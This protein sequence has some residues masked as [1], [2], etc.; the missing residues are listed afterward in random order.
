MPQSTAQDT[1]K[2]SGLTLNTQN[3][4]ANLV[5]QMYLSRVPAPEPPV[6]SENPLEYAA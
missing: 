3:V 1:T 4:M 6:F 5:E 2:E